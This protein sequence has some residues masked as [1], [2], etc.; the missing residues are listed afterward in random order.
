M[1]EALCTNPVLVALQ[2]SSLLERAISSNWQL[3]A[4]CASSL[5]LQRNVTTSFLESHLL[6]RQPDS[7]AEKPSEEEGFSTVDGKRV[8]RQG[9]RIFTQ[10][11]YAD[12][13]SAEVRGVIL[14]K[15]FTFRELPPFSFDCSVRGGAGG[16][17]PDQH[18]TAHHTVSDTTRL[19]VTRFTP[20]FYTDT[21][22]CC[23]PTTF[24]HGLLLTLNI[25]TFAGKKR[26]S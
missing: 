11:G 15:H 25:S 2:R 14:P 21:V 12:R 7:S 3:A 9:N 8:R 1:D 4:P 22:R 19:L 18:T 10:E 23:L 24:V 26:I 5:T 17:A 6:V 20:I 16:V 13:R